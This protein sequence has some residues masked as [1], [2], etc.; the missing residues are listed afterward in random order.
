MG[1]LLPRDEEV[2]V[3]LLQMERLSDAIAE[4][5]LADLGIDERAAIAELQRLVL[6]LG[7]G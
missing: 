3:V 1:N 5:E 7:A 6:R 4:S 2:L